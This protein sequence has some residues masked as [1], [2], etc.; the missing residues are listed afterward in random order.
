VPL[1]N[2]QVHRRRAAQIGEHSRDLKIDL[3]RRHERTT[4]TGFSPNIKVV[5]A[6]VFGSGGPPS[7]AAT[8]RRQIR[9]IQRRNTPLR[10]LAPAQRIR[11]AH[12][13]IR[14]ARRSAADHDPAGCE[15]P[16]PAD[17]LNA[18]TAARNRPPPHRSPEY[19]RSRSKR[20]RNASA[21][22]ARS[23]ESPYPATKPEPLT[24]SVNAPA[25]HP[26][27]PA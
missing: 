23:S 27:S 8:S 20:P 17:T 1:N 9:S 10:E 13:R 22:S 24:A 14:S 12:K 7:A 21:D 4:A 19:R 15:A 11:R 3:P 26:S 18:D 6:S 2:D 5:S 25:P 16:P